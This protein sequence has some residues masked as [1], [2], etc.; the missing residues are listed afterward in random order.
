MNLHNH[1]C[2]QKIFISYTLKD[3][4]VKV[5]RQIA[6]NLIKSQRA[7]CLV[8]PFWATIETWQTLETRTCYEAESK[9]KKTQRLLGLGLV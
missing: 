8:C 5:S 1:N 4:Y 7:Q 9:V 6:T 3:W 2:F